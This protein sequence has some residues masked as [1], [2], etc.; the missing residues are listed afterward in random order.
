VQKT[1]AFERM[2]S[3]DDV[4]AHVED[5]VAKLLDDVLTDGG[6][7]VGLAQEADVGDAENPAGFNDLAFLGGENSLQVRLIRLLFPA[8]L[9]LNRLKRVRLHS[10]TDDGNGYAVAAVHVIGQCAAAVVE[11]IRRMA[12]DVENTQRSLHSGTFSTESMYST[13]MKHSSNQ[14]PV[15]SDAAQ[16]RAGFRE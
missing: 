13:F 5:D 14:M 2:M 12:A 10:V 16:G 9:R 15:P 8:A 4:G 3:Y 7:P 6:K 1:A 11:S